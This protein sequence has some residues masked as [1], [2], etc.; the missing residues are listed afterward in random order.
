LDAAAL[1]LCKYRVETGAGWESAAAPGSQA[2]LGSGP[3]PSCFRSSS[4]Q[5]DQ[6]QLLRVPG[7]GPLSVS[8]IIRLRRLHPFREPAHLRSLGSHA[9]KALDFVTLDGRFFGR[10]AVALQRYYNREHRWLNNSRSGRLCRRRS[11]VS[12]SRSFRGRSARRCRWRRRGRQLHHA[13]HAAGGSDQCQGLN[14]GF[15]CSCFRILPKCW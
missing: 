12:L 7:L 6:V 8:R 5:A 14:P 10:D 15:C 9:A 4:N 2:G 13:A 11:G 3:I 1:W